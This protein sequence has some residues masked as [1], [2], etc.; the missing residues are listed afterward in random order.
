MPDKDVSNMRSSRP[1]L[2][3]LDLRYA[4][5]A[6]RQRHEAILV[7]IHVIKPTW[8]STRNLKIGNQLTVD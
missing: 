8:V 7:D 3:S 1:S 6:T 2:G 4:V 5:L